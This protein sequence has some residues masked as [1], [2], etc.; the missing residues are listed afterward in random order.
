[1]TDMANLYELQK[2]DVMS[3]KVRRRLVQLKELL[4][5]SDELKRVQ[6]QVE[7]LK[8]EQDK[9]RFEQ[10]RNETELETLATKIE[11]SN[12]MLMGGSIHNPKELESL[13][14]NIESLQRQRSTAET[15][16][17]EALYK[18]EELATQLSNAES[19]LA[20]MQESWSTNQTQL[21]E[22][23]TKLKR[24]YLVLKKQREQVAERIS[25]P[26]LQRYEQMRQ[27]KGGVAVATVEN[28]TCSACHV[29]LPTGV[30]STVIDQGKT[31]KQILCPTCGRL[32]FVP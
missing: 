16:S 23:D 3:L 19:K 15:N 13:Q 22:E 7:Q 9:W 20:E 28:D 14:A 31:D 11:E 8:A 30:L 18:S 21:T 12:D 17:V 25:E 24:A 10:Q 5:E 6:S 29:Q 32:L 26:L 2:I 4:T 1:M 27:R